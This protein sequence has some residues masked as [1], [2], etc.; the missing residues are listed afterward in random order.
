MNSPF[1]D[2]ISTDFAVLYENATPAKDEPEILHLL[3]GDGVQVLEQGTK[4]TRVRARGRNLN[5]W[6]DKGCLGGKSLLEYYFIDVGQGDGVLIKTPDFQHLLIDGGWP[7]SSQDT[8]KNAADFVDWK[9]YQD[10]A[11]NQIEL[12]AMICS[13]NDQ[14]HYGGLWDMLN[15]K[16][17]AELDVNKVLVRDF[18][19]AGLGWWKK[20]TK[21][22]LGEYET[23]DGESFFTQLMG[24]R[25]HLEASV[26]GGNSPQL[27]GE[28]AHF[29]RCVTA[30]TWKAGKQTTIHRL[31]HIDHHLPGFSVNSDDKPAIRVLGPVEFD[32]DGRKAIRRFPGG[33]SKNTNGNSI[34]LRVDFGRTRVI[35]TGDLNKSSQT[36]LLKDY[37]GQTQEFE[38]DVAKACHHGS[39]DVSYSFLQRLRP[40]VTV[41]SSGDNEGHDHPR[42]SIVAASA[43][44]GHFEIKDDELVSPLV[45]STE[46]ARSVSFGKPFK[47]EIKSTSGA[48]ESTLESPEDLHRC[49]VHFKETKSGDRNPKSKSRSLRHMKVVAGLIYGLVNVRTDGDTILCATLDEK[50]HHWRIHKIKSRF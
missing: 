9:F 20:G 2:Y 15:P 39:D 42:P 21:K 46:L 37:E 11:M 48:V 38:C 6:V 35:L 36:F 8:G 25:A 40:A 14:D 24:D 41:I 1:D 23:A 16:E 32:L 22:T 26:G 5:G 50:D 47:A 18:Y 44:T 17:K 29:L 4:R 19:H 28:W 31:S 33:D 45:F 7:R 49:M 27:A 13:H 10:Y 3:W 30:S 34:M 43:T 12:E